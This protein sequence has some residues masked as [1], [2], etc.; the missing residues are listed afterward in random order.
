MKLHATAQEVS[1]P[2][3]S[4]GPRSTGVAVGGTLGSVL[5]PSGSLAPEPTLPATP[6]VVPAA[7]RAAPVVAKAVAPVNDPQRPR[8]ARA[9]PVIPA[10]VGPAPA[11]AATEWESVFDQGESAVRESVTGELPPKTKPRL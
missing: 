1:A 11:K 6:A 9:A 3:R 7:V 10:A 4:S 2:R 5:G 8:I